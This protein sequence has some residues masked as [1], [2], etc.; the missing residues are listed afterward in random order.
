MTSTTFEERR[1]EREEENK[2][3]GSR[4]PRKRL[5]IPLAHVGESNTLR[6]LKEENRRILNRKRHL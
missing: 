4:P 1:I 5:N 2:L 3:K 6:K